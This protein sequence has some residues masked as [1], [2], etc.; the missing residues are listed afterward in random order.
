MIPARRGPPL[1]AKAA[2][3]ALP[4]T[5]TTSEQASAEKAVR[6]AEANAAESSRADRT[7][8]PYS[9]RQDLKD[10]LRPRIVH[11]NDGGKDNRTSSMVLHA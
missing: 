8:P 7:I 5:A 3:S 4:E 10:L 9:V 11:I 6:T 1:Q 2:L